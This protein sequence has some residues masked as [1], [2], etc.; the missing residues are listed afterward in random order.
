[1]I[2]NDTYEVNEEFGD[3]LLNNAIEINKVQPGTLVLVMI[4]SLRLMM[5][6]NDNFDINV[7]LR[8]LKKRRLH[9]Y[10]NSSDTRESITDVYNYKRRKNLVV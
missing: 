5:L 2:K 7:L 1:M 9:V 4:R 8:N 3:A 10:Q 6:K